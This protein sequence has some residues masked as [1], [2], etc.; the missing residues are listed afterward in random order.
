MRYFNIS[1]LIPSQSSHY[2]LKQLFS[3]IVVDTVIDLSHL[4]S[5]CLP[6]PSYYP[7]PG[8]H[9]AVHGL[10]IYAYI[11]SLANLSFLQITQ[12][13]NLQLWFPFL[14]LLHF[15][16]LINCQFLLSPASLPHFYSH[17]FSPYFRPYLLHAWASVIYPSTASSHPGLL[18]TILLLKSSQLRALVRT[19]SFAQSFLQLLLSHEF[20]NLPL[21]FPHLASIVFLN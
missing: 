16:S 11:C 13:Q 6:L 20:L 8:F 9:H 5:L 10:C 3:I 12:F 2:F 18:L 19:L 4:P 15:P 14:F 1:S 17:T 21:S 7:P